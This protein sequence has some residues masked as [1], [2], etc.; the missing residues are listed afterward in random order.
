MDDYGLKKKV[1]VSRYNILLIYIKY[2]GNRT[3]NKL[4]RPGFDKD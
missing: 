4:I 2:A 1:Y 3:K